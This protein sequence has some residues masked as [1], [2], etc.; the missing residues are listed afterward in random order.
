[1][2]RRI[3][4]VAF[5]KDNRKLIVGEG[6]S[7]RNFISAFC[8]KHGILGFHYAYS[9]QGSD[10]NTSGF[11][12]F[13]RYLSRLPNIT[14]FSFVTDIVILCDSAENQNQRFKLLRK[15]IKTVKAVGSGG[16]ALTF[17]APVNP[18]T[19]AQIQPPRV[20]ALMIPFAGKGGL[21]T[22]CL[23]AAKAALDDDNKI[24]GWVDTFADSACKGWTTEKRD[25]LRLQAF[26][27]AASKKK[28]EMHFSQLFDITGDRVVPLD[29]GEFADVKNFL[30]AVA[31]L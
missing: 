15:Q 4:Q 18:N 16:V 14:G 1:M 8:A 10:D 25:K 3:D 29:S 22:L 21:E 5:D 24:M 26:I 30:E 2:T 19:L 9:G 12:A 20:H 28:P 23:S 7:D 6:E 27:S 11:D 13:D 31:A 17:E